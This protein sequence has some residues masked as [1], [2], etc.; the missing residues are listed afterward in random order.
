MIGPA[1]IREK[2]LKRYEDVLSADALGENPFPLRLPF[3]KARSG[4][5]AARWDTLRA[6]LAALR[7]G[8][9]EF[10]PGRSY[11]VEWEDRRDRLAGTQRF[12]VSISFPDRVSYL[13]FIGKVREAER[14]R[15]DV[16]LVAS[17]FPALLP[18]IASK[19]R[20]VVERSGEWPRILAVLSWLKD[21]PASGL[22]MREIPAVDD[23]KYVESRKALIRE[24]LD[25]VSPNGAIPEMADVEERFGLR[26]PQPMVRIR[27][28]DRKTALSRFSGIDDLS[29]PLDQFGLLDMSE[30]ERILV[31]ENKTTFGRADAFLTLPAMEGTIAVFGSGY[32]ARNIRSIDWMASRRIGYW[33]DIDSHGLRILG[34]FRA[35]FP[36]TEA[37]LMDKETFER[38]PE[39]RSDAAIDA[40]QEPTGLSES[41][42]G[43]FRRLAPV[44]SDNRLEQ[45]RIPLGYAT[46]AVMDWRNR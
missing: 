2:A 34:A 39:Y 28:L 3:A 19:P 27:I 16:D 15:S 7:E 37:L 46:R 11:H 36:N 1:E 6:E 30:I 12:P 33:G 42:L 5:A 9:D 18:W 21:N 10:L 25:L 44:A 20:A 41:E 23:T 14:F 24:L 22:Y 29:L 35:R 32:A 38:F 43:L 31:V 26:K 17:S 8:S 13:S 40:A 4:E 45:E